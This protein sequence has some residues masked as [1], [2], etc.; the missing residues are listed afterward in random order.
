MQEEWNQN[1]GRGRRRSPILKAFIILIIFSLLAGGGYFLFW[2]RK[3]PELTVVNQEVDY[4][5]ELK[6]DDLVIAKD[7]RSKEVS[8]SV[9][10]IV[11]EGAEISE[12]G[13]TIT[14]PKTGSYKVTVLG[15]DS[16][17]NE[18]KAEVTVTVYDEVAPE[19]QAMKTVYTVAYNT[20]ITA[21]N[22]NHSYDVE[23]SAL[24]SDD[25][26]DANALDSAN[27][28]AESQVISS[29][30]K[31]EDSGEVITNNNADEDIDLVSVGDSAFDT[32]VS[33]QEESSDLSSN[34]SD[35]LTADGNASGAASTVTESLSNA[36]SEEGYIITDEDWK[37]H[38]LHTIEV[39]AK[40]AASDQL[41]L[42]ILS[43]KPLERQNAEGYTL[44]DGVVVF[45]K[46]GSYELE[47]QAEDQGQNTTVIQAQV[48][49]IDQT[50]PEITESE[51]SYALSYGKKIS[52]KQ[53]K[54]VDEEEKNQVISVTAE[55]E[56]SKKSEIK[57]SIYAIAPKDEAGN[58]LQLD[59]VT[60]PSTN[61]DFKIL[62]DP[63]TAVTG[64]TNDQTADFSSNSDQNT[65][66][67]QQ[68]NT[69]TNAVQDGTQSTQSDG[70]KS[71][72]TQASVKISNDYYDL[73]D[74]VATF[75]KTG[76]YDIW[77][78]AVDQAG[79]TLVHMVSATIADTT[80]PEFT[81][82]EESVSLGEHETEHD[83]ALGVT[84]TDAVDGD[85]SASITIDSSSVQYTVPGSY[86]VIY[87]AQDSAG[88]IAKVTVKVKVKDETPPV[89]TVPESFTMYVGGDK[90]NYMSGVSARDEIDGEVSVDVDTSQVYYDTPG[91]YT[92]TY[93]ASDQ[94]G[95]KTTLQ[96][97]VNVLAAQNVTTESTEQSQDTTEDT[98]DVQ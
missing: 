40:D 34:E 23:E 53:S 66:N 45:H 95:N 88:N 49:V 87:T 83:W 48:E 81:G 68:T 21:V 36:V 35:S 65:S 74:G 77:I 7:D 39:N 15:V 79:N 98:S 73:E 10:S 18:T 60:V 41:E 92:I 33:E 25:A 59:G 38:A 78:Q 51:S 63:T 80:P 3:P 50:T 56:L 37:S 43:V 72:T 24:D 4:G 5:D 16:F 28:P 12:D 47:I 44:T 13:K 1:I 76:S 29:D 93:S 27:D 96:A 42:T 64:D 30:T 90:P 86:S 62:Y 54:S 67:S 82:I 11:P 97:T 58:H 94:S 70:D 20:E 22:T 2:D 55:D 91:L 84:A 17:K 31:Q 75:K 8:L 26:R 71:Q 6:L 85:V 9:K 89:L 19:L 61:Q 52:V 14:F 69:S 57:L 32:D 46:L